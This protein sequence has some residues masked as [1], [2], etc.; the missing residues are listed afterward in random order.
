MPFAFF[1]NFNNTVIFIEK[2]IMQYILVMFSIPNSSQIL[3][4]P[5]LPNFMFFLS[6]KERKKERKKETHTH[7]HTHKE[8][9][10]KPAKD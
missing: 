9:Q 2:Q 1:L 4:S 10:N 6:P 5:S 3:P 8:N 7:T